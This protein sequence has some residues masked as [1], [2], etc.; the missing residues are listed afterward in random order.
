MPSGPI[1]SVI[2][3]IRKSVLQRDEDIQV[4]WRI[5][6]RRG[7]VRHANR[8][9]EPLRGPGGENEVDV[10][11]GQRLRHGMFSDFGLL[12]CC[13]LERPLQAFRAEGIASLY[14]GLRRLSPPSA[15]AGST[16]LSG[17]KSG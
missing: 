7:R 3:Q 5:L 4:Y 2:Q 14:P 16:D 12:N 11:L 6:P 9:R 17:Q 13:G 15:W 1:T 10:N 8:P